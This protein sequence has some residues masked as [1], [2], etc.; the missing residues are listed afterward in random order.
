[1]RRTEAGW[2]ALVTDDIAG[3]GTLDEPCLVGHHLCHAGRSAFEL[4]PDPQSG[5][6]R[7]DGGKLT[8]GEGPQVPQAR[9]ALGRIKCMV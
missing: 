2:W 8:E 1:M 4:A 9:Q 7:S 5:W 3:R 6:L